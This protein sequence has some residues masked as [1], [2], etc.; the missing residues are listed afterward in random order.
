MKNF[1]YRLMSCMLLV[2]ASTSMGHAAGDGIIETKKYNIC[3]GDTITIDAKQTRVF[4]DTIIRDTISVADPSE[5]SIYVYVVNVYPSFSKT[6]EREIEKGTSFEWRGLTISQAGTYERVYKSVHECDSTYTLIVTEKP[7][8]KEKEVTFTICEGETVNFNGNTYVNAGT[9]YSEYTADSVYKIIIIKNPSQLYLQTGVLDRTNPYYWKYILDG[10]TKTDTLY[11]A[12]VYEH[13]TLNE[14][15]GC[16]D[17]YRLI[18]KKDETQYHFVETVTVCENERF[19]WHGRT[20]LNKQGIGET[21]HYFDKYRTAAD[22][23]SIYELVLTVNPVPRT[24]QTIKFCG[25]IEWKGQ[26]ITESKIMIDTVKSI[27]YGCDSIITTYFSKG[28]PFHKHDT[29]SIRPGETLLWR[30]K[31]ITKDGYYQEKYKTEAGCDSIYSIGVGLEEVQASTPTRTWYETICQGD[32]YPWEANNK[33]YYNTGTYVDTVWVNGDRTQGIDSLLI[34]HLTVNPVY[35]KTERITFLSFPQNYRDRLI[36]NPDVYTFFYKSSLGC[37]S[38]ITA[39]IDQEVYVDEIFVTQCANEAPY[40]WE[41]DGETYTV[42]GKYTKTEKDIEDKDS[43][44]H[45]LNLTI[46]PIPHIYVTESIC[47][48]Q[49]YNFGDK[50]LT[51]SGA[52]TETFKNNGCDSIVTLTLNVMTPD[53]LRLAKTLNPGSQYEWHKKTYKETGVYYFYSTN[54]YG[55]EDVEILQLTVNHVDTIDTTAIICPNEVPFKWHGITANQTGHFSGTEEQDG[56]I[57]MYR[58]DLTVRPMQYKDTTFTIC[59][60]QTV[61]FHGTTY[62]ESGTYPNLIACDTTIYVH[63]VN[64]PQQV[65]ETKARLTDDHGYTWTYWDNGKQQTKTFETPGTYEFESPNKETGCSEI[66]RLILTR[67]ATS[68]LFKEEQTICQGDDFTWHGLTNLSEV[69]GTNTYRV[70]YQTHAGKDSI[71]Q[72]TLTVTAV[73]RTVKTVTFC[74]ETTWRGKTYTQDAVI[75]D[76][77]ALNTGCYRIERIN[78]DKAEPFYSEESRDL[79]Q[80]K[81]L[82]WHGQNITTD[83]VYYDSHTTMYGCDSI[84][85]ITVH[86]I[87]ASPES[88]QYSEELSACEGD[89]ILW[90]GRL[91]WRSGTY[92]DTVPKG[93][94]NYDSIFTLSFTV[95]PAPKDTIYQHLY[96]CSDGSS[97]RYNGT[98]YFENDTIV[99]V[100]HTIHGCDSIVKTYMHFNEAM[101][102]TRTD[103]IAD[104]ELPYTWTYQLYELTKHDTVVTNAGTY[105]HI[106]PSEGGC[107]SQEE[108]TLVVVPTYLYELDTTVCETALPF[109][110][111]GQSLQHKIGETKQYEDALKSIYG[112][113]SIYRVN[114]TIVPAPKRTIRLSICENKDTVINGKSYF[115]P[116]LYPVGQ[117]FHDTMYK[118]N[119]GNECDSII[120]YEITKIPQ[121]HL[122]ETKILHIGDTIFWEG[123]TITEHKTYTYQPKNPKIDP[124]TGCEIIHD[125]R[126]IAEDRKND[127]ICLTDLPYTWDQNNEDYYNT[128]LYTD[129]TFDADGKI[130]AFYTLNLRVDTV[131]KATEYYYVCSGHTDVIFGHRY[132]DD[133][134]QTDYI[135]EFTMPYPVSGSMCE[136]ELTVVVTVSSEK[137]HVE[138]VILRAGETLDWNK[139]HIVTGGEYKDTTKTASKCDSISILR[140]IEEQRQEVTICKIDTADDTHPD[141][142]YPYVWPQTGMTYNTSGIY[143]D[144]VF[145]NDGYITEFYALYLTITQPYDTTVY[146]HGCENKGAHWR[147][148]IYLKDTTFVDRIPVTPYDPAN[149]CDSVFHVNIIM[150][151]V[152]KTY[153]DTTLCEY[154]LPLIIGRVQPDTIWEERD[155]R[156]IYDTTACG[157]DS[158]IEGYLTII[159]KLDKNDST[160]VCEDII[161]D[162]PV[163]LGDTVHPAFMDQDGGKWNNVWQGKWHGVK[164]DKDTIVWDCDHRYFHHI[165]VRPHQ[166]EPLPTREYS[167]CAGDSVQPFWPYNP[168]WIKS[169]TV[170]YDTVPN[171]SPFEDMSG[172]GYIHYERAYACDSVTIWTFHVTDTVHKHIYK[173]IR[174]GETYIFNDSILATTGVYDSIGD[175][176]TTDSAHHY[177]KAYYHLHLNVHPVYRVIDTLELCE[178]AYKGIS[179]DLTTDDDSTYTF[180]FTTPDQDTAILVLKDSL[181]HPSYQHYDHYYTLVVLYHQEYFTQ[182][183]DTICEGGS[184]RFDI[185]HRDN[186]LTQRFVTKKGVYY[187]TIPALN[188]CDSIIQLYLETRDSIKTQYTEK[189]IT[190]RE[191]PYLWEHTWKKPDG[192][193]TT[194]SDT[195]RATGVYRYT[196]PHG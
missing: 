16:F 137:Q 188:G 46:R 125:L 49:T 191:L 92:V 109:I 101:Y 112:M 65:Y 182:I 40:K 189:T 126:V 130:T 48:G 122:T 141:K 154:Q 123:D 82:H 56:V 7:G 36:P 14:I 115:N 103:T 149:P 27:R 160:F 95:W 60:D 87:P 78:L 173:D 168:I 169:D 120:Y 88:N 77:V 86:V 89:T 72:L 108:L 195:L 85:K 29:A 183:Y 107:T 96:T 163:I 145:D 84:Y 174:D 102:L 133:P 39:Y 3:P 148:Q 164:Y 23:D 94:V 76:T 22:Q 150:D 83:G 179:Y 100:Y 177:C 6:E 32:Y 106:V 167:I 146:V 53:T 153:I 79:P 134:T 144:T 26:T 70:E 33:K 41:Y 129:T 175:N 117:I 110:W 34:L 37:D 159:P 75:Y 139:Y 2:A 21:T 51:E 62:S 74:G 161:K 140:V 127:A 135:D 111:R 13:T 91:I 31:T 181:M 93:A 184:R 116:V 98:D 5:D 114:L 128:G 136:G 28:I 19:D 63:I 194:Y 73:E 90:R 196:M 54:S 193:D 180:K 176:T 80:G 55:C 104:T 156:H 124:E 52:Y 17:T 18:L 47:K 190:D 59:G 20:E 152:Y 192:T 151:K 81:V 185:H 162:K 121:R 58:L 157:C 43:V 67:D 99:T 105:K 158:I 61:T 15:T 57:T 166:A 12:G 71:Y 138:T 9:Y 142:K 165:I 64:H 147:D 186:T 44:I 11:E 25:S 143:T 4:N 35:S 119:P 118:Y 172:H 50:T 170:I 97:I 69:V 187:D 132:G 24:T 66:W 45:I 42:S 113:D 171:F 155:F 38:I 1:L 10:E 131:P 8:K 68:Y 178:R 30:G